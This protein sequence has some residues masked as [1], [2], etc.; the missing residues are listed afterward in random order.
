MSLPNK[1]LVGRNYLKSSKK[2]KF[3]IDELIYKGS[4]YTVQRIIKE[5]RNILFSKKIGEHKEVCKNLQKS[6][7]PKTQTHHRIFA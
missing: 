6:G 2:K 1:Y 5:K 7:L 4:T 3:Q